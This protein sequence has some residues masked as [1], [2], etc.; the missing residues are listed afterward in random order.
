MSLNRM[1]LIVL[2]ILERMND[3]EEITICRPN[4]GIIL[5]EGLP[6]D[7]PPSIYNAEVTG[8]GVSAETVLLYINQ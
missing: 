8:I 3:W 1:K 6:D 5:Y 4:D 7:I 2:D